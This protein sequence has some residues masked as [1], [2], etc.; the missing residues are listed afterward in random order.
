PHFGEAW[1]R[2]RTLLEHPPLLVIDAANVVGSRPNG[3]WKDRPGAA[4]RLLASLRAALEP[5]LPADLLAVP[6]G[7]VWPRTVV[8]LEGAAKDAAAEGPHE[9]DGGAGQAAAAHGRRVQLE[10]VHAARS[11]DDEIVAQ[12]EKAFGADPEA[13]VTV[14]TSDR[15]LR[16]RVEDLGARAIG[17]GTLL[18]LLG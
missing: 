5:G 14:V 9:Y 13:P 4:R 12:V 7:T 11:G 3:W 16:G 8:V 6:A 15:G 18:D 10:V 2:L 17:S 1:P